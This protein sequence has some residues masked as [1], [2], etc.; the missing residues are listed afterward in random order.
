MNHCVGRVKLEPTLNRLNG[1]GGFLYSLSSV[2][3]CYSY[4]VKKCTANVR[5]IRRTPVLTP[6]RIDL[7]LVPFMRSYPHVWSCLLEQSLT[8]LPLDPSTLLFC[9]P[10]A[11]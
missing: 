6:D 7:A 10:P 9:L 1:D 11:E 5:E 2:V 4:N 3:K 8:F